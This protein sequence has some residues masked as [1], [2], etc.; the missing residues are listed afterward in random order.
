MQTE[1]KNIVMYGSG[2]VGKH[3][4]TKG[5]GWICS[6]QSL[7]PVLLLACHQ[8]LR[9]VGSLLD[10]PHSHITIATYSS[11][12]HVAKLR[13]PSTD[14]GGQGAERWWPK[15]PPGSP[16]RLWWWQDPGAGLPHLSDCSLLAS[17]RAR[18]LSTTSQFYLWKAT[19]G[20]RNCSERKLVKEFF[21][22]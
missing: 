14:P 16:A 22:G 21:R 17:Y 11:S 7:A 3:P 15:Q 2:H 12:Q 4:E 9:K 19:R 5:S 8:R 1:A 20:N 10:L 13:S 18:W 6:H